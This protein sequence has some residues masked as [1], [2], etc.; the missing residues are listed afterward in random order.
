[1]VF[2]G[3]YSA[4]YNDSR[5][6]GSCSFVALEAVIWCWNA[7]QSTLHLRFPSSVISVPGPPPPSDRRLGKEEARVHV[8]GIQDKPRAVDSHYDPVTHE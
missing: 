1:M 8:V 4:Q 7:C 6:L 3:R 2:T 5:M